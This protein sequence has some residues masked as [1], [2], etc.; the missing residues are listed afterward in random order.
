MKG[1]IYNIQRFSIHDGPGV[2]TTVFFKGCNLS[3]LWCHNPESVSLNREVEIYAE[4]CI[5]CGRCYEICPKQAHY[6][7]VQGIHRVHREACDGCLTCTKD[8]FAEALV[9]IGREITVDALVKAI[10]SDKPYYANSGGGVTFSGGECLLQVDFL[11]AVLVKCKENGIHT[12]IDTAGHVSWN[13]FAKV[14][15]DTDLFLYD[16]KAA[17]SSVHERITGAGN[18]TIIDNLKRLAASGKPICIRIPYIPGVND[19]QMEGIGRIL[20]GLPVQKVELMPYHRLG[21]SKYKSLDKG[22]TLI[23]NRIPSQEEIEKSVGILARYTG[24]VVKA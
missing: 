16:V 7:D 13:H 19:G 2:R 21:E 20:K 10:L 22:Y 12:A 24:P 1:M 6:V 4:R 8:C 5:G 18:E 17:D 23:N 3:C 15:E 14:L 9:G 11:K